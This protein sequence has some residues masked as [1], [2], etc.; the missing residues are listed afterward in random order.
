MRIE[1]VLK[2]VKVMLDENVITVK[3]KP[4][5]AMTHY[6]LQLISRPQ[7]LRSWRVQ[8]SHTSAILSS[9]IDCYRTRIWS[10]VSMVI[11]STGK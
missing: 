4:D 3:S 7:S 5:M 8:S 1:P 6:S 2:P 10:V 9:L 11:L